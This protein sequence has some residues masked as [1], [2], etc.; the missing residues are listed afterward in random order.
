LGASEPA[1]QLHV[2]LQCQGTRCTYYV[3]D[4]GAFN[5]RLADR[6]RL[7]PRFG[8]NAYTSGAIFLMD[9][10]SNHLSSQKRAD[11]PLPTTMEVEAAK[12]SNSVFEKCMSSPRQGRR[13]SVRILQ[14]HLTLRLMAVRARSGIHRAPSRRSLQTRAQ[15]TWQCPLL[16]SVLPAPRNPRKILL[17]CFSAVL[18]RP[19]TISWCNG[20]AAGTERISA[21]CP[22]LGI[23]D[24]LQVG[25]LSA[26][27]SIRG[28][29]VAA[30]SFLIAKGM[31]RYLTRKGASWHS[32]NSAVASASEQAIGDTE[33]LAKLVCN[34]EAF[35]KSY[36]IPCTARSSVSSGW[37]KITTSSA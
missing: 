13:G 14:I 33:Y 12:T 6:A 37:Q 32:M 24:A 26:G 25:S 21:K 19:N 15:L 1:P 22:A 10:P 29:N 35:P 8:T 3:G 34:P 9:V 2:L 23:I 4:P 16:A 17:I 18:W 30:V 27:R 7:S 31:P 20:I 5:Q 28:W 36:R 11:S